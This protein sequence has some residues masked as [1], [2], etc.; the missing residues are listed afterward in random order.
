MNIDNS[1]ATFPLAS[2]SLTCN[3]T[4]KVHR[5]W[6]YPNRHHSKSG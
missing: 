1:L 6:N 5:L 4:K 2:R 3:H